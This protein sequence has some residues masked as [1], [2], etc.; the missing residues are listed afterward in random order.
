[1]IKVERCLFINRAPF[2]ENLEI[3][4]K[5]GVNVLCGINGRGKTTILSYIV[6]ALYEMAKQNYPGSF[7]GR[8]NKYYRVSSSFHTIDSNKPSI[9]YIRFSINGNAI[10]YIDVR[11]KI[12]EA[13]YNE[14]VKYESKIKYGKIQNGLNS[15]DTFKYFSIDRSDDTIKNAF[16]I[17]CTGIYNLTTF[18]D[19]WRFLA[20][21]NH[22]TKHVFVNVFCTIYNK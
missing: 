8:E 15:S 16:K 12:S 13:E 11:G 10:D 6:D 9:V 7:E 14:C 3:V 4:F 18:S 21:K 2:K 22:T 20:T 19:F 5:E 17:F 1:M